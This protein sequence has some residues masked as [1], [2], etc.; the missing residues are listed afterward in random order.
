MA[1]KTDYKTVARDCCLSKFLFS[2]VKNT[3][4]G[5]EFTK[6]KV[7]IRLKVGN[8]LINGFIIAKVYTITENSA[9]EKSLL[10]KNLHSDATH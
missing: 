8:V 5:D 7:S 3:P 1:P 4:Q 6:N 2:A 9:R 10:T